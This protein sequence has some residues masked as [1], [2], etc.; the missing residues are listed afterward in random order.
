LLAPSRDEG[1]PTFAAPELRAHA[2]GLPYLAFLLDESQPG[3]VLGREG[4]C[5][6]RVPLPER[7]AI[8]KLVVSRLRVGRDAKSAKD[9]AQAVVLCAALSELASGALAAARR[10][11]PVRARAHLARAV[12]DARPQLAEHPRALDELGE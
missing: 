9:V 8:H 10:R 11:I 12:A 7:F 6:V 5:A 3:A 1:Y 4:C 2:L